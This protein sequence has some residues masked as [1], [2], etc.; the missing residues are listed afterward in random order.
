MAL[1]VFER[2]D[3]DPGLDK[4]MWNIS[5]GLEKAVDAF[6]SWIQ[7]KSMHIGAR[8]VNHLS[9]EKH[10]QE[11]SWEVRIRSQ[12]LTLP[13]KNRLVENRQGRMEFPEIRLT[14]LVY[15]SVLSG[16]SVEKLVSLYWHLVVGGEAQARFAIWIVPQPWEACR[17]R[18]SRNRVTDKV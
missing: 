8:L 10:S 6:E 17:N 11:Q 12:I 1:T 4:F 18:K 3:Q 5:C 2:A 14:E 15:V 7:I 13:L 16:Y 9:Y